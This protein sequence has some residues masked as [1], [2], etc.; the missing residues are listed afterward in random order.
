MNKTA[1]WKGFGEKAKTVLKTPNPLTWGAIGAGAGV[2]LGGVSGSLGASLKSPHYLA[3]KK[4]YKEKNPNATSDE[5]D[6][7]FIRST[8][9]LNAA[10]LGLSGASWGFAL[11][12]VGGGRSYSGGARPRGPMSGAGQ[13]NL[14]KELGITG[15]EATKAEVLKKYKDAART[16]HPDMGGSNEGMQR[17]NSAIEEIKKSSWFQKLAFWNGFISQP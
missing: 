9:A 8:M 12:S 15:N 16:T 1:F 13:S 4:D 17:L 14:W 6:S 11:K 3:F 10:G 5:V 7:A 2:G